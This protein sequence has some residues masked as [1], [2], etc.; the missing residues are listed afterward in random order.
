MVRLYLLLGFLALTGPLQ[1][2]SELT[3]GMLAYRPKAVLEAR[4]T[5]LAG[6]LGAA[7]PEHRVRLRLL[8]QEEFA[9]ALK[10]GTLD[11]IFTNPNHF[12]ALRHD[13]T[14][15]GALATLVTLEGGQP[16]DRLGGVIVYRRER[17]DLQ[18]LEDLKGKRIAAAGVHFLGGYLAQAAE[19]ARAGIDLRRLNIE[20]TGQPHDKVIDAVLTGRVDAG[21]VRSGVLEQM[22]REGGRD[23]AVLAVLH[24][25]RIADFPYQSS[26]RLYP[27][28]PFLVLPKVDKQVARRVAAALLAL[29]PEHPVARAA[30]IHGFTV[31]ADYAELDQTMRDLRLPPYDQAPSFTLADIW[32]RHRSILLT[33][34]LAG[35]AI[36]GLTWRLAWNNR[37]LAEARRELQDHMAQLDRERTHLQTLIR[38]LPDLIWLKSPEGV[39]LACNPRFER[40]FGV[41]EAAILGRTDY[42]FVAAEVADSFREHD[43]RAIARGEPSV[44]E[45]WVTFADDGHRELLETIKTPMYDSA[46]GLIGVLGIGRDITRRHAAEDLARYSAFQAG[47]AEMSITVLHNIGNA[48]TAL[49]L[50]AGEIVRAGEDLGRLAGL[51]QR[52]EETLAEAASDLEQRNARLLTLQRQIAA[53]LEEMAQTT[54]APRG[55]RIQ[56]GVQH[57]ADIVHLHQNAALPSMPEERCDPGQVIRDALALQA[58]ILNRHQIQ[59]DLDIAPDL[60]AATLS[61]NRLQQTLVNVLKNAWESIAERRSRQPI[62]GRIRIQ[63]QAL[64]PDWIRI[65]VEDNGVGLAPEAQSRLF[66]FGHS[67]KARGSG[68]GLHSAA[69]FV[70]DMQGRIR[71]ESNGSDQGARLVMELPRRGE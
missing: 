57:I 12:L 21:F 45:E 6:Y 46:G 64:A 2:E 71:L 62:P 66:R 33:V 60:G 43:R 37:R 3:L 67:S 13:N 55:R 32:S 8:S 18:R 68:F 28:W 7:L 1:A 35:L 59:V 29:E 63:A 23:V 20:F 65:S 4:W 31:P 47:I 58:D 10:A 16:A 22:E 5:P 41:P 30:G 17:S 48:V 38:A 24:P 56:T 51:L 19:L 50:D 52:H 26:T 25:R 54:L 27:E 9:A 70:Q 39:F 44:N 61:R 42:D 11:F 53:T 40:L 36:L 69:L 14:L 15:S 34:L 49:L